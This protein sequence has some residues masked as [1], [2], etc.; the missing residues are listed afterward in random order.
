MICV[1]KLD[2]LNCRDVPACATLNRSCYTRRSNNHPYST[3]YGSDT[4]T[5]GDPRSDIYYTST[6]SRH[7]RHSVNRNF[8]SETEGKI[9]DTPSAQNAYHHPGITQGPSSSGMGATG[10]GTS[11]SSLRTYG[12]G[13]GAMGGVSVSGGPPGQ[14][15]N[16]LRLEEPRIYSTSSLQLGSNPTASLQRPSSPQHSH[17]IDRSISLIRLDNSGSA[18]AAAAA[19]AANSGGA[20]GGGNSSGMGE[21]GGSSLGSSVTLSTERNQ[22]RFV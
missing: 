15:S 21:L 11:S 4:S 13:V 14:S 19:A 17:Y 16:I 22:P 20:A 7:P 10:H 8:P 2:V 3:Y 9:Y 18:A 6:L 12:V 5:Y 1:T